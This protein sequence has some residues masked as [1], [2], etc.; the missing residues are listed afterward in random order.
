MRLHKS[1]YI[2]SLLI[3]T[4]YASAKFSL[5]N[6]VSYVVPKKQEDIV[7]YEHKFEPDGSLK[8]ANTNG[9]INVKT[10]SQDHMIVEIIKK[11]N[12]KDL[13]EISFDVHLTDELASIV[14]SQPEKNKAEITFN[15]IV[16]RQA[17]VHVSTDDGTIKIHQVHNTINAETDRGDITINESVKKVYARTNN[18]TITLKAQQLTDEDYIILE[19]QNGDIT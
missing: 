4:S 7:N 6:I 12:E 17:S 3:L 5:D 1:Y 13:G 8:I 9:N 19:N 10:W 11:G 16:P 15:V 18:G 14:T 2:F